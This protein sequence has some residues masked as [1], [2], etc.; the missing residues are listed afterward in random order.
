[1]LDEM[2]GPSPRLATL[3]ARILNHT[4]AMPLFV[5]EVCR[6]Q[7][8]AGALMGAWGAFEP[9]SAEVELGVPLTVQGVI[10]S[11]IDRLSAPEK[12]LLQVAAAIGPHV[13][14]R[15]LQAISEL[16]EPTFTVALMALLATGMLLPLPEPTAA[17]N[18]FP[19]E[20]VRQVA[21]DAV[22]GAD[23]V[24]LHGRILAE[25]EADVVAGQGGHNAAAAAVHHALMARE[26]SRAADYAAGIARQCL[27]QSALP[28]ATRY[29]EVAMEAVD[30]LPTSATR[31]TRAID[32]RIEARLA[33]ANLGRVSRWLDLAKEAEARAKDAG[34]GARRVAALA[35]RAAAL[36]FCGTPFEAVEAGEAAV[37]EAA[38]SGE[39]GWLGYAEYGL[40]QARYVAGQYREAVEV[41]A[42]AYDRFA[43]GSASPPSGASSSHLALLCCMMTCVI[44]S[45]LG[46]EPAAAAAQAK[47]DAIASDE[48]SRLST[49]AAG[50][51]RGVLF[52]CN[53]QLEAAEGTLARSLEL[54]RQHDV[55]LFV[56]VL[57]WQHGLA[58]LRLGRAEDAREAFR[59]TKNEAANLGH[60]SLELRAEIGLALCD[61]AS[62]AQQ[63]AALEIVCNCEQAAREFGYE[64]IELEALQVRASLLC[65]MKDDGWVAARRAAEQIALRLGAAGLQREIL[66]VLARVVVPSFD[67]VDNRLTT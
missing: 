22:L 3:K 40:G 4:G 17:A 61:T 31:E 19:H 35:V 46:D 28:D 55:N 26:W 30:R 14:S 54:A 65:A 34:D 43:V 42:N 15:L 7:A 44:Q 29:F 39:P 1:M 25:L 10:A 18:A 58:L 59:I 9:A 48:G 49:I 27:A 36:N 50:F 52:L 41:L 51:S 2:L 45:A 53:D 23:K 56:P 38:Q 32:L 24:T 60:R 8:E 20:L 16:R 12:R 21:Y 62:P 57:G 6:G 66:R 64:P 47:V 5:E 63:R 67:P 13:P 11:R 37:R 33:Y